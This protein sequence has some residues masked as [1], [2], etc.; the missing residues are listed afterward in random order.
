MHNTRSRILIVDDNPRNIQVVGNILMHESIDIAYA[1]NGQRALEL[2]A[3][4]KFDLVLLDIMM[5]GMDGFTVCRQ[6][7]VDGHNAETPVIFL[8]A[9]N[10]P[11]SILLGFE[12]GA[13]DYVTKP[14]NSAEL[15]AR[16]QTHLDL[17]R[18]KTEL[19]NINLTLEN[20]VSE[21]TQEL[22]AALR[23]LSRLEKSKSEFLSIISHELRGP[24][25]G[26]IGLAQLIKTSLPDN[27]QARQLEMLNDSAQRLARFAEMAMLITNL[28]SSDGKMQ[29]MPTL[30]HIPI[31]MAAKESRHL[32]VEKNISLS[33]HLPEPEVVLLIDSEMIRRCLT[34]LIE[35]AVMN[36]PMNAKMELKLHEN[37]NEAFISLIAE[38]YT[39]SEELLQSINDYILT[40][41]IITNE[42]SGLSLAAVK[43]IVDAHGGRMQLANRDNN[44]CTCL[45]FEKYNRKA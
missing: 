37:N 39:F 4:S 35:N 25:S 16:V 18:Q 29:T 17:Y 26:I 31:E 22:E 34:I 45:I 24:L 42:S 30:A 12:A 21:R 41:Q 38:N 9:R 15:K 19:R 28:K 44:G 5:P 32:L 14:F 40:G 11:S 36:L 2:A 13:N 8:T 27:D 43:L 33:V 10:D 1:T 20:L 7:R 23:Q 6:L 3:E